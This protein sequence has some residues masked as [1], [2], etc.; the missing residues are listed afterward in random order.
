MP[1]NKKNVQKKKSTAVKTLQWIGVSAVSILLIVYFLVVDTRGGQKIPTIGSVNGKPI[2][3]TSTSPYGIAFKQFEEYY[4]QLGIQ[5]NNEMY[6]YI[7]DLAFRKAVSAILLDN[8]ARKNINVSDKFIVEAMKN[9]FVETNGVFNKMAYESFIKN[10]SQSD[11][12]RIEKDLTE[13]ILE[14][15]ISS[16]L[17]NCVK[18]NNL[19][20]KREYKKNLTKKDIEMLYISASDIVKSNEIQTYDLE[21]YFNNNKTNF[22]Q[23]DISWIVLESGGVADNLYKTLKDDITLFEKNALEKSINTNNYKLGYLTR[24]QMPSEDFANKIFSDKKGNNLLQPI[25]ANGYYYIVLVNDIRIPEKYTD[26]NAEVLKR[27][28]L[29]TNMDAMLEAEKTKQAEIL[30]A[31]VS[32]INNLQ[33]LNGNGYI[34]YYRPANPFSYNQ[35]VLN[36]SEGIIIPDSSSESFYNHAFALETNQM[37]GV[38]KLDNGVAVMRLISEEKPNMASFTALNNA[39]KNAL[40]RELLNQRINLIRSQWEDS[41][42]ASSR[43]KKYDIRY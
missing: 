31:A 4:K 5:I 25:Y 13:Y 43:V 19:E 27:E 3:Y 33:T 41:H 35:G 20:M 18:L 40:I 34:K 30:K 22:L 29:N 38:I 26:V 24:M 9:Q 11:K 17:F 42:I 21:N 12:I 39:S 28:Y 32:G 6:S 1:S 15:T 16:E 36:T 10:S 23:A 2:Y 8:L 14:K 37:S 7:E